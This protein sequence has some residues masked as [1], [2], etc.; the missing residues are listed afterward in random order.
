MIS[1][2]KRAKSATLVSKTFKLKH[3]LIAH[4]DDKISN[5]SFDYA[6]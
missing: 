3:P 1:T 6:L 4:F 5:I 2:K